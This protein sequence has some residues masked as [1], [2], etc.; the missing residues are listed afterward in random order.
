[1][2][3]LTRSES[4]GSGSPNDLHRPRPRGHCPAAAQSNERPGLQPDRFLDSEYHIN[5]HL[6]TEG[7]GYS[8]TPS[9]LLWSVG[10]T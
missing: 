3:L 5:I 8:L 7:S 2:I 1:M 9:R 6:S 10:N 4:I